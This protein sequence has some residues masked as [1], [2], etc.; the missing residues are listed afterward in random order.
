MEVNGTQSVNE[1][2]EKVVIII[3]GYGG[4]LRSL[5]ASLRTLRMSS[6]ESARSMEFVLI[7]FDQAFKIKD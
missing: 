1:G 3:P 5:R 6:K 7:K 4:E 2:I